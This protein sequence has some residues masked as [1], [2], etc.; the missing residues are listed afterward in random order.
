VAHRGLK[1]YPEAKKVWE[2]VLKVTNKRSQIHADAQYNLAILELDS[3]QND[4]A[5]KADLASYL[6][7]APTSHAKHQDAENKCKEVKCR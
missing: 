2:H 4:A 1:E 5:G 6:Q 7:E 3:L